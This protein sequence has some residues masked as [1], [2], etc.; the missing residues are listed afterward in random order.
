MAWYFRPCDRPQRSVIARRNPRTFSGV[1]GAWASSRGGPRRAC[2]RDDMR[3]SLC[4]Q[5]NAARRARRPVF[6]RA[7]DRLVDVPRHWQ[8]RFARSCQDTLG[9]QI[10]TLKNAAR[11]N[12][13]GSSFLCPMPF[14]RAGADSGAWRA[15][16]H[17][18]LSGESPARFRGVG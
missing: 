1:I 8:Q 2:R 16:H 3:R 17:L 15:C 7:F 14:T 11:F 18:A 10:G 5:S 9:Y 6:L 4:P 12:D 13:A